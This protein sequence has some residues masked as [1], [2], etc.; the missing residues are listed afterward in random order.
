MFLFVIL[1]LICLKFFGVL[2]K[3]QQAE[4]SQNRFFPW[5]MLHVLS[6]TR[7]LWSSY[8]CSWRL[9]MILIG[10]IDDSYRGSCFQCDWY[11]SLSTWLVW[12]HLS[13]TSSERRK[14]ACRLELL[15]INQKRDLYLMTSADWA[16]ASIWL[17]DRLGIITKKEGK[18]GYDRMIG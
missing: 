3:R 4:S 12:F 2:Y 14:I 8:M 5:G 6:R 13:L 11:D 9:S 16:K 17:S 10:A 1:F 18:S 7:V 15:K